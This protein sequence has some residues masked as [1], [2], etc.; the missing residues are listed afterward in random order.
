MMTF[1][2]YT[3]TADWN[4]EYAVGSPR[5][6]MSFRFQF[7]WDTGSPH[8]VWDQGYHAMKTR[9]CIFALNLT[10]VGWSRWGFCASIFSRT[11]LQ[12]TLTLVVTVR[13]R[14]GPPPWQDQVALLCAMAK[15]SFWMQ[16]CLRFTL[17]PEGPRPEVLTTWHLWIYPWE[18][19]Y[20][21]S[22]CWMQGTQLWKDNAVVLAL[23]PHIHR[24]YTGFPPQLSFRKE[25]VILFWNIIESR[26]S[27]SFPRKC[28]LG[29]IHWLK[30]NFFVCYF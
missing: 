12:V 15:H 3:L 17:Q 26:D 30:A 25:G 18:V 19:T 27:L 6:P 14:L 9:P 16:C 1:K 2:S 4:S 23:L 29:K 7:L 20:T 8:V 21:T 24:Y 22:M 13:W 11:S 5:A 28:W 10:D